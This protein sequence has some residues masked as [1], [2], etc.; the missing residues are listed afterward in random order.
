MKKSMIALAVLMSFSSFA[1]ADIK[2]CDGSTYDMRLC[3]DAQIQKADIELN[4]AYKKAQLAVKQYDD[5]GEISKRLVTAE[6]AWIAFRDASCDLEG[7]QMLGGSG[8]TVVLLGCTLDKTQARTKELNKIT[9]MF[10]G[11]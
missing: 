9:K 10:S 2:E 3:I 6:R 4:A 7:A 11:L 1:H 5:T 8:E